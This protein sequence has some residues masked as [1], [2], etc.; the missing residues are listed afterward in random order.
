MEECKVLWDYRE[1]KSVWRS[2]KKSHAS[3]RVKRGKTV[4]FNSSAKEIYHI[5]QKAVSA[6]LY[7]KIE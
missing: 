2:N 4:K 6:V 7:K 5:T 3:G 1:I